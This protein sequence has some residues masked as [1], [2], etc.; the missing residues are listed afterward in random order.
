MDFFT[1]SEKLQSLQYYVESN[2]CANAISLSER[3][4]VSKRTVLRMVENLR[5]K[6]INIVY[7]NRQKKY[8]IK[9]H[10]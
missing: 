6:G 5:L 4:G 9:K 2:S 7:C 3:L 1:Y 10:E 8:L